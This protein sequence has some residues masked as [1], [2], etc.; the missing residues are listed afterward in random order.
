MTDA[1]HQALRSHRS[2]LRAPECSDLFK[3]PFSYFFRDLYLSI[4]LAYVV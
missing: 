3:A 2:S 4:I 1:Q